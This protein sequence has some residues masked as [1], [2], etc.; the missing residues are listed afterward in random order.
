MQLLHTIK[1][2]AQASDHAQD[3]SEEEAYQLFSAML[4]G[5]VADL[6]LGALLIALR[7]KA[8]SVGELLG[9]H[10]AVGERLYPMQLP[11]SATRP[12]VIGAYGGARRDPNLLPLVGLLLKRLG[13]PVVFH[14]MLDGMG[15]V[16][17]VYILREFGILPSASLV[18]AQQALA[19]EHIV[20][21]PDA[22]LCPG[23]AS[24]LALR[25]RLGV[26]NSAHVVA[27][28]IDPFSGAAVVMASA[29]GGAYL[30]KLGAFFTATGTPALLLASTEGEAFANPLRRPRIE[31]FDRGERRILFEEEANPVKPVAGLPDAIDAHATAEWMRQALAGEVPIPH[32]LVNQLACC[33]YACGYTDHMNQAKAIAAV[34]AG[35]LGPAGRRRQAAQRASR[36]LAR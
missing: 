8:E 14:G 3:L 35:S 7:A 36:A 32:P 13:V 2:L 12:V 30:D 33:L 11:D 28:L 6:E 19:E 17:A 25:Y 16:A 27:K 22:V 26:R 4:D 1:H 15:R 20:F 29:S 21:V 34:E 5:G 23:L 18:H 10:R 24:L 9:F 31:H